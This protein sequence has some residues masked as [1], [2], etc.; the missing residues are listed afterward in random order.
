M[1]KIHIL[2]RNL[3]CVMKMILIENKNERSILLIQYELII[4]SQEKV[5]I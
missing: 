1:I 2:R 5:F 4:E 3:I